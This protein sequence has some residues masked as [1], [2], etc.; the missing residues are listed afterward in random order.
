MLGKCRRKMPIIATSEHWNTGFLGH[1]VSAF[2][3]V[4]SDKN[5]ESCTPNW[6]S[7]GN[8]EGWVQGKRLKQSLVALASTTACQSR[9]PALIY[10]SFQTSIK[11][12][13]AS[14]KK[15]ITLV[16]LSLRGYLTKETGETGC[17]LRSKVED[18]WMGV[19]EIF[20]F[21]EPKSQNQSGQMKICRFFW[22]LRTC[23]RNM[24]RLRP[25]TVWWCSWSWTQLNPTSK[26]AIL[27]LT[28]PSSSSWTPLFL[29]VNCK[30]ISAW[31]K[32][33]AV[34][35]STLAS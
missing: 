32:C 34:V 33:S 16:R 11:L 2:N 20:I 19:N 17:R 15:K 22:C 6:W 13:L 7:A 23:L 9:C 31:L 30:N 4:V 3:Q 14:W 8:D 24:L 5:P 18:F 27:C 1:S 29:M 21:L 25:Y 26:N 10:L 12:N 28:A 35:R